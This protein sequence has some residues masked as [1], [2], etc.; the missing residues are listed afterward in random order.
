MTKDTLLV[1]ITLE[2]SWVLRALHLGPR[3]RGNTAFLISLFPVGK[4]R[5]QRSGAFPPPGETRVVR[6]RLGRGCPGPSAAVTPIVR[7][8]VLKS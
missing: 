3:W 2:I 4:A 7:L 1:P 6:A 8:A 5:R